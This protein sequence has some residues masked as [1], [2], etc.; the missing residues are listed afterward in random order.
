MT[1]EIL[2]KLIEFIENASPLIWDTLVRQVY[3]EA[4][5]MLLGAIFLV[6]GIVVLASLAKRWNEKAQ[7]DAL[8]MW[9]VWSGTSYFV[10]AGATLGSFACLLS[11]SMRLANPE[12]YAIKL[13]LSLIG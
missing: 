1:D 10:I 12:F 5:G 4:A 13:I 6:A 11:A 3:T 2:Q 9:D 8:G 7:D